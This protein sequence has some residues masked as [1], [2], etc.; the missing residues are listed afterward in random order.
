[1]L[2]AL[3]PARAD[4]SI[5]PVL[6]RIGLTTD[7]RSLIQL[8]SGQPFV[9]WGFNY[10][11]DYKSRLIEDYWVDEWDTVAADFR[12]MKALGANIVRIHLSVAPFLDSPDAPNRTNVAQLRKLVRL[13]EQ[14]GIYLDV[15]GLGSYRK[16]AAPAWYVNT[17]EAQRWAIQA[18]FWDVVADACGGSPAVAWYDLI[19]E[20][21]V[22]NE[23]RK[24]GEWMAGHLGPFWYSQFITLDRAGRDRGAIARAWVRQMSA[25][26]RRHDR[27]AL[28]TVGML[29]FTSSSGQPS[30]GFDP[31]GLSDVLDLTCVHVYPKPPPFAEALSVVERFDCCAKPLII[32][33]TF[34]LECK[35]Q[36]M[37]AFIDATKKHADGWLGFY[38]GQTADELKPSTRPHDVRTRQWLEVFKSARPSSNQAS[39][40]RPNGD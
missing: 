1:M 40:G 26:I 13:C 36:D 34:P 39:T 25:A 21:V 22:P 23:G 35:P 11:R 7:K 28:I 4:I 2:L 30:I 15:T 5:Q 17:T 14:I 6:E 24:P 37:P 27:D 8:P 33:E 12:E 20:P 32:E 9:P 29:P 38:W 19:N 3:Q 18:K 31:P 16:E 10:D